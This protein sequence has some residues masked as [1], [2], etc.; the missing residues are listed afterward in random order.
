MSTTTTMTARTG[1]LKNKTFVL[2]SHANNKENTGKL[3]YFDIYGGKKAEPSLF[4]TDIL[5]KVATKPAVTDKSRKSA[6][7]SKKIEKVAMYDRDESPLFFKSSLNPFASS[8]QVE[9]TTKAPNYSRD[10][11]PGNINHLIFNINVE[12]VK[13]YC[14]PGYREKHS[15]DK[16]KLID[17]PVGSG[18]FY[19]DKNGLPVM[20]YTY[21][22]MTIEAFFQ[23]YGTVIS[24]FKA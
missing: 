6:T 10:G 15:E 8:V 19:E 23:E 22:K 2:N 21:P 1:I 17:N 7:F 4:I 14:D 3:D 12:L 16:N 9:F 20:K 5:G 13:Q 24:E 11:R 18:V